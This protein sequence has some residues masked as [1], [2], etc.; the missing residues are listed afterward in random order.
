MRNTYIVMVMTRDKYDDYCMIIVPTTE[1]DANK[2]HHARIGTKF[3][4]TRDSLYI[5]IYYFF[6]GNNL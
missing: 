2:Y 6:N 5:N 4:Q 3:R 1:I